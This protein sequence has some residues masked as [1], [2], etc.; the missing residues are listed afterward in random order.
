MEP[1]IFNQLQQEILHLQGYKPQ[2]A[3]HSVSMKLGPIE[4]AFPFQTFPTRA[5]HEFCSN[6]SENAAATTGFITALLGKL[7]VLPSQ[8]CVWVSQHQSPFPPAL[9][10]FGINPSQVIFIDVQ[11]QKDLL[12]VIEETLKCESL[13]AVVGV[14][15]LLNFTDSRRLQLAVEQS[16]VTGL[17]HRINA[18]REKT[19][20]CA[21]RWQIQS[22]PSVLDD[23]MPGVGFPQWQINLVKVRNG[24]PG[25]W[26]LHWQ[27]GDFYYTKQALHAIKSYPK[28]QT[29]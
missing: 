9:K 19:V 2:P 18:S 4:G 27:N 24:K 14:T 8:K 23:N 29:G 16:H 6:S 10:I 15:E 22:L 5:L 11:Q 21:A 12:W 26:Q 17:I 20:A 1:G 28:R 3:Q 25:T 7:L 13:T